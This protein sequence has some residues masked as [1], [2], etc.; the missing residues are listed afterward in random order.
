MPI[1]YGDD[2]LVEQRK[3]QQQVSEDA[4][5]AAMSQQVHDSYVASGGTAQD[6]TNQL[7]TSRA[8]A[9]YSGFGNKFAHP[10]QNWGNLPT[11]P[12]PLT[13]EE[14]H[15]WIQHPEHLGSTINLNVPEHHHDALAKYFPNVYKFAAKRDQIAGIPGVL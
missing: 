3:K 13:P 9:Y 1:V 10:V 4:Q 7:V 5:Q 6:L 15:W 12:N 2:P 8:Q 14:N 11:N